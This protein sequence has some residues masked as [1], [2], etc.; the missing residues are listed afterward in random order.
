[1]VIKSQ[2]SARDDFAIMKSIVFDYESFTMLE[3]LSSTN[4]KNDKVNTNCTNQISAS[5]FF[6]FGKSGSMF[7][8]IR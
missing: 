2:I 7:R 4:Y 3:Y 5:T 1:M 6:Q 8:K